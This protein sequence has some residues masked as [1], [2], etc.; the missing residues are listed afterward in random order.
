MFWYVIWWFANLMKFQILKYEYLLLFTFSWEK[1]SLIGQQFFVGPIR[2]I[3]SVKK[4]TQLFILQNSKF[5]QISKSPD[6][7]HTKMYV[8]GNKLFKAY[9]LLFIHNKY[10]VYITYIVL[11]ISSS[12]RLPQHQIPSYKTFVMIKFWARLCL[13]QKISTIYKLDLVYFFG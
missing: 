7:I 13:N 10:L 6:D 12:R 9:F 3:S 2:D 1:E 8:S 4:R 11:R 5:G